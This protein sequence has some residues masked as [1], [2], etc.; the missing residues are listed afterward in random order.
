MTKKT[1]RERNDDRARGNRGGAVRGRSVAARNAA[2]ATPE[3]IS[4]TRQIQ[5]KVRK[6]KGEPPEGRGAG[7]SGAG[8]SPASSAADCSPRAQSSG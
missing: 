5:S 3:I 4:L 8:R 2:P 1:E 7:Q 6:R